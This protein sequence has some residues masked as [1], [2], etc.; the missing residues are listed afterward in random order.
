[1]CMHAKSL[2]SCPTLCNSMDCCP[3][4]SSVQRIL[5]ARVLEWVNMPFSRESSWPRDQ[6]HKYWHINIFSICLFNIQ[7]SITS[8]HQEQILVTWIVNGHIKQYIFSTEKYICS[9][10]LWLQQLLAILMV[11]PPFLALVLVKGVF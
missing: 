7:Y 11:L 5:Q 2:Q 1:M 4:G 6:T 3:L 9:E 10:T 8:S